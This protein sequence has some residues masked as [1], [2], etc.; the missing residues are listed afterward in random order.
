[1]KLNIKSLTGFGM[2]ALDGEIGKVKDFYFD[3]STW[4]I[5][6]LVVNTGNWLSDRKVLIS[7]EAV[8]KLD[9]E[10]KLFFVNLTKEQ[11][12]KSPDIDTDKP[13]SRQQEARLYEYYPWTSYWRTGLWSGGIITSG[14]QMPP[15]LP[16]EDALEKEKMSDK[17]TNEDP[18]LR[19]TDKVI[20]Y[21]IKATDG[22]IG[23]VE[24]FIVDDSTWRIHFMIVD[25]GNWFPGKKVLISPAWVKEINWAENSV[26]VNAPV[27][28]VKS[29]PEYEPGEQ[30][31]D[32]Y[33]AN[34]QNYYGKYI[35]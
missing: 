10:Q 35:S 19:S 6:Y 4:T 20:G 16:L 30:V 18:N 2:G 21:D 11:V 3:D 5:R 14:M 9:W 8:D 29:S 31:S 23:E 34:L 32:S 24:D 7:P 13:V 28:H 15:A 33:E 17:E 22:A 12:E 27:Q 26:V 25:T 1:M